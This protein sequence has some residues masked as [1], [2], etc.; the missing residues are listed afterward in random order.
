MS[1]KFISFEGGEGSGKSTQL[2]LLAS[3][4]EKAGLLFLATREPGGSAGA[5]RIRSLLVSGEV[6]S[7]DSLTE[8]LLFNA[9]RSDHINKFIKP[10]MMHGKTVICD[11]FLDSTMVYQGIGKGLGTAY[12]KSLHH[13]LFGGF[14]P[15]LTIILDIAPEEGLKRAGTRSDNE[16]RFEKLGIEFH[17]KIRAGFLEIAEMETERCVVLD[18]N[19]D[20]EKLHKQIVETI[21]T[22]CGIEL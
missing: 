1:G 2:R 5:E 17:K 22:R 8:T 11:R 18:A 7:W 14:M 10:A 3:A 19:Q 15:N 6:N 12:I 20:A 4:F 13:M 9:A 16:N 21:K